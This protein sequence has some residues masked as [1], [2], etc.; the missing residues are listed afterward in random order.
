MIRLASDIGGTFTDVV[1]AIGDARIAT[2]VLTTPA[3]P[4]QAVMAGSEEV[5]AKAGLGFVEVDVVVHGTTLA[6][7]AVIERKG[8]RT[9]L[10][11]TDGFRDVIEIADESRYDQ[12]DVFIEK[13]APLVPRSLRFTVGE[14][15]DVTGKVWRPLDEAAVADVA[16]QL[17]ALKVEAVAVAFLH[18]YVNPA[19][20]QRA[21]EIIAAEAPQLRVTLSSEVCPE[22]RE[23]ERTSTAVANAYVQPLMAGYL[24]RLKAEHARRGY[25][26]PIH[27]MT[28][29]G[30]LASLETAAR[31][32]I[33]LV[34]SGPAGG[35]ILA[36]HLAAERGLS[37]VLSFDMGGTTAKICLIHD[38]APHKARSFEVDRR[39]RFMKG[40]GLPVRIPVIEMVE[41]GAGGGSIARVDA[42][43]RIQVGPH[44]AASAPGP[45][46]YGRGGTKPTVTDADLALGRIDAKRFAG[47]AITLDPALA[48]RALLAEVGR[49]L[50]LDAA[51]A[52]RGVSEIVD[53][54]MA[55][56]ARVHAVERGA[57]AAAHTMVAFGGAAPLHAARLAEKLGV[58]R[59]IVPADAG[60]G[61]AIGFLLAPA[62]YELVQSRFMRLDRFDAGAASAMLAS[63]SAEALAL[64]RAAAGGGAVTHT[65]TAFMRYAGQGHEIAVPLPPRALKAADAKALRA[66]FEAGYRK[67]FNRHIPGAVI[68]IMSWAV[69]A[70][71][72]T[73]AP[74]RLK[75]PRPRP[76]PKAS[77]SRIIT[78]PVSGKTMK[79]AVHDRA[80]LAPGMVIAGPAVIVEAGTSTLVTAGFD[81]EIDA[82]QAL[83]LTAR[84]KADVGRKTAKGES[85]LS[86]EAR[87]IAHQVQ[88]SRLIAVVE[89]QAQVLLRTAFSAIVR[90]AGDLSAG[91]FTARGEMLAQAVTGT[92]GHV[93]S[94]AESV[95]HFLAAFPPETMK[96]GDIYITNDPWMGT[97]HLNDFVLTT[98]A[99][100]K[101]KLVALFSC[102]SHLMD[103]GGI[104]FGPDGTDVF[105][106][107]LY[108]PLLKLADRGKLNETL[109][110]MI[111]SNTRLPVDTEGD[112]YSLAAC[113][114]VGAMRLSQMMGE[115]GLTSLDALAGHILSR[116]RDGVLTE[117]ASLPKGRFTGEMTIDGYEAPLTL[118][119]AVTISKNG[120]DVD[121]SGSG[122][123]SRRGI[124]VPLS[125]TTAY[126]VFGLACIVGKAIPNNAGSLSCFTVR[127]PGDCILNAPKPAAVA[128]RHIIGQMLPDV[129]FGALANAIPE[130][131]PAEGTSCLWNL[132]VR[133]ATSDPT[134]GNYGFMMA[135]TSNG[136]TG[137]R[138]GSDGLSATAYPSGVKGTPVEIAESI[139]PLIFWRK[140]FRAGSGGKG[141]TRGG[142]GQVIEISSR[143]GEP[144]D[145]LAAYD[146][147]DHPPRGRD[148]GGPGAAG[149]VG[150][151]SGARL[152]GKGF[153]LIPPDDRL[154]V[155]TPGGGGLG[156]PGLRDAARI[157]ADR[158][159]GLD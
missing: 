99:F 108:I 127:A 104:G 87:E 131:V 83:V 22:M 54:N 43:K 139:T 55:N 13:T 147:I 97:G 106:E 152:K 8:A 41:I 154:V 158:E 118:K 110:A 148:G 74:A 145:L 156:D 67:L 78:D 59:I 24:E 116:S 103:I 9:A 17:A 14:R 144:F 2:K 126:T 86:A 21:R 34:E 132:N 100:H 136:G 19:H 121:F 133:G 153:Q 125:Y 32:P 50:G 79:A 35:A 33:R 157:A 36:A 52:A 90:E 56:A 65:R 114:D 75:R 96:P 60:V 44:S 28:S 53:E 23:Y 107:G 15:V 48:E 47:G 7:N 37:K 112:L 70:S 63:M 1:L 10:I 95:K 102:T 40:S 109:L 51:G 29:G 45:A 150:L 61:S 89:E 94:M 16:R 117:I 49:P 101:G 80:G 69:A 82:G 93:N 38:A 11:A 124:N 130:R 138:P 140:E 119:A 159:S 91:V 68:E 84:R 46:A 66:A 111:R 120:I 143:I 4:E 141:R 71:T 18:A 123:V 30:S 122:A 135:V 77:G 57:D 27:L 137:A 113:N 142:L 26:R 20:E 6:T 76:A 39:S 58:S 128:S 25:A 149:Y 62:A 155:M 146:R 88:W 81:A 85:A 5:L 151:A 12:Y 134:L 129:V 105:M 73:A 98:P 64:A 31:F 72:K 3:A 92:P 115:F 42:L